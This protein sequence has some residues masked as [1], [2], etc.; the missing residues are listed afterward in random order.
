MKRIWGW[1][2]MKNDVEFDI[3]PFHITSRCPANYV[4]WAWVTTQAFAIVF[5]YLVF[6]QLIQA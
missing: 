2:S 4:G 3:G 5:A 1:A 6:R